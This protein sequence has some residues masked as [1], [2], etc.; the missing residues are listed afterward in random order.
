M[1]AAII[2][3]MTFK[4]YV[5]RNLKSYNVGST[6]TELVEQLR[7]EDVPQSGWTTGKISPR[8]CPWFP[9]M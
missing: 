1:E 4:K 5:W 3:Q 9:Q 6:L 2:F 7:S 8:A